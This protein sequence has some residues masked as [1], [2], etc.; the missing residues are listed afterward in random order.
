MIFYRCSVRTGFIRDLSWFP[1]DNS[2]SAI[3][4]NSGYFNLID[5]NRMTV[6]PFLACIIALIFLI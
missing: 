2:L 3:L 6:I 1:G 4:T 5:M